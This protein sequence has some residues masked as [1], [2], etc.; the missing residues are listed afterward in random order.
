[1]TEIE[2]QM[3][4]RRRPRPLNRSN[5]VWTGI[6]LVG[7]GL[8]L[9]LK[10]MDFPVPAWVFS[11]ETIVIVI[12]LLI[13]I[14]HQFRGWIWFA[15]IL[16]GTLSQVDNIFPLY[17]LRL[18]VWPIVFIAVGLYFILRPRNYRRR[19][20]REDNDS[21]FTRQEESISFS[22]EEKVDIASVFG[23]VKK[24]VVSKNFKGGEVVAVM[25]GADI[26]LSQAD[27]NG[28]VL[29]EVTCVMGG[30][31][32]IIPPTWDVQSEMAAVFGGVE[33]KRD[34]SHSIDPNKIL[35]LEGT[36]IFG[37]LEI[38]NF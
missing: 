20:R 17:N 11:W 32:L 13:G 36:C 21:S 19:D 8:V 12:G 30:A 28:K 9:M 34:L 18:Y 37:G 5:G 27:I 24:V 1:M 33:D 29:L 22:K 38:R 3:E 23:H 6:F 4:E 7:A 35:V 25:G 16:A 14:K 26:N 2:N 31:K 10:R 15:M